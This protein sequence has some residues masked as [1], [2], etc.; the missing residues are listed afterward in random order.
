MEIEKAVAAL[1]GV[2]ARQGGRNWKLFV[3]V[4]NPGAIGG[5]P[6]VAVTQLNFGID[7]D[8]GKVLIE[9]DSPLTVLSPEDVEAVR[10]SVKRGQS[11]HAY[12]AYKRQADRIKALEAE[13]AALKAANG[14]KT[15]P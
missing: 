8:N 6:C 5:T 3:K 13:V 2:S 15:V 11:W 4:L 1:T 14:D 7:W 10:E 9:T 12:Q